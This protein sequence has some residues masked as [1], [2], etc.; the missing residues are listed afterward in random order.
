MM[1]PAVKGAPYS[2]DGVIEVS[3]TLGDGTHIN[4]QETYSIYRDGEGRM[5]RESGDEAWISDPVAGA[6]YMLHLKEQTAHKLPLAHSIAFAKSQARMQADKMKA[7][8]FSAEAHALS[9]GSNVVMLH[10]PDQPSKVE[11]LG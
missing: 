11:S 5:R 8:K 7:E 1:G 10:H 4:H 2:A 6:S 3:Q 9:V